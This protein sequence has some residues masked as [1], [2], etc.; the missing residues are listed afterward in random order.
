MN[1]LADEHT[2]RVYLKPGE[3]FMSREP[4][5]VSTVLG[6]CVS[7]TVFSPACRLG[8]ICHAL[9]PSGSI[10]EGFRFVDSTVDYMVDEINRMGVPLSGCQIKLFGGADV[11]LPS[12]QRG[13]RLSVGQQNIIAAHGRLERHGL[14]PSA[15]DV[16]G[17]H[18]RK[19]FF[20]SRTGH[21]YLKKMNKSRS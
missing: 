1:H 9:L 18:G 6:S 20:D 2:H 3:L 19:L 17:V 16:G 8:A 21:V 5:L 11:L 15:V 10:A 4:A 7:V 12:E 13:K 14:T